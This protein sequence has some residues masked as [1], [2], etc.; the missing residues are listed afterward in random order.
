MHAYRAGVFWLVDVPRNE[1]AKR[2]LELAR[3]GW[4]ITY[5]EVV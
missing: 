5:S 1:A 2:R 3:E 4:V